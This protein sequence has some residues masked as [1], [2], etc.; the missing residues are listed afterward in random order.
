M[1]RRPLRASLTPPPFPQFAGLRPGSHVAN[2]GAVGRR[3]E[4]AFKVMGGG[5]VEPHESSVQEVAN[6]LRDQ[7]GLLD[8]GG[9]N[10]DLLRDLDLAAEAFRGPFKARDPR[11]AVHPLGLVTVHAFAEALAEIGFDLSAE[12][13]ATLAACFVQVRG[14]VWRGGAAARERRTRVVS[15]TCGQLAP[16]RGALVPH[17]NP[18]L[19][20]HP[21]HYAP[22]R[23]RAHINTLALSHC[24]YKRCSRALVYALDRVRSHGAADGPPG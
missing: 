9:N 21:A 7:M 13:S 17:I 5:M 12:E 20:P 10:V 8:F 4:K 24:S 22:S 23:C 14:C 11:G 2:L 3:C 18:T 16:P 19:T 15:H 1:I 6:E